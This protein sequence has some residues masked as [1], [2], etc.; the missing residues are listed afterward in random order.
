MELW[1]KKQHQVLLVDSLGLYG[2]VSAQEIEEMY[3][4]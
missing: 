1:L 3:I 2:K 4:N